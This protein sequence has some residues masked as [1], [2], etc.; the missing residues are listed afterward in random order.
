MSI[1]YK[2]IGITS[3]SRRHNTEFILEGTSSVGVSNT[4]SNYSVPDMGRIHEYDT[5]LSDLEFNIDL[6]RYV[7]NYTSENNKCLGSFLH[8]M[9]TF[10]GT[11]KYSISTGPSNYRES[12][13]LRNFG[14]AITGNNASDI[15]E[16]DLFLYAEKENTTRLTGNITERLFCYNIYKSLLNSISYEISTKSI[17]KENL[18]F[19]SNRLIV[20]NLSYDKSVIVSRQFNNGVYSRVIT[21]RDFSKTYS[22]LPEILTN[23]TQN[24]T[25]FLDGFNVFGIQSIKASLDFDYHRI[26]ND[27]LNSYLTTNPNLNKTLRIP[28]NI[29]FEI[30]VIALSGFAENVEL[31]HDKNKEQQIRIVFEC[32]NALNNAKEYFVINL[33]KKNKLNSVTVENINTDNNLVS[34]KLNYSNKNSDFLVYYTNNTNFSQCEQNLERY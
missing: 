32:S 7:S 5:Y 27:G 24:N 30:E 18:S 1:K 34:Y 31:H 12:V 29:D 23:L 28:L 22:V 6:E 10:G 33:G 25:V 14:T 11:P 21:D 20:E 4:I 26:F 17:L 15:D 8:K 9:F 19:S 16:Y 2:S 13:F 3:K